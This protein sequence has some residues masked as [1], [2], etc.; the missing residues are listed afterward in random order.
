MAQITG[1]QKGGRRELNSELNLVPFIDLLSVCICFL[2]ISA[3]WLHVGSV[4]VKQITGTDAAQKPKAQLNVLVTMIERNKASLKLAKNGKPV[5]QQ[6]ISGLDQETFKQGFTEQVTAMVTK[7]KG[8]D[9][10]AQIPDLI[11][12]A[13]IVP[14]KG[15]PY[16][17]LILVMDV[18]RNHEI[19]N[20]AVLPKAG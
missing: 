14:A 12:S 17:N 6:V 16:R 15:A 13:L 18:L 11:G 5:F 3:V 20:L 2:L 8:K 7:A 10:N 9:D 1:N 19:V 4:Q